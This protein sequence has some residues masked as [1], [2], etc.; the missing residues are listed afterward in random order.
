MRQRVTPEEAALAECRP[1]PKEW[2]FPEHANHVTMWNKAAP[3]C[4][5][6]PVVA[7]CLEA[8][9]DEPWG[10]WGGTTPADRG[11]GRADSVMAGPRGAS[12]AVAEVLSTNKGTRVTLARLQE[13]TTYQWHTNTLRRCLYD[14]EGRGLVEIT[15]QVENRPQLYVW[16]GE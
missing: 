7:P 12:R 15:V 8:A 9:V 2:F 11:F 1:Y 14:L 4:A 10:Y 3:I 5:V 13:L 16:I 6:C